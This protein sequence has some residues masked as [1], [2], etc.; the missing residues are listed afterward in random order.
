MGG[1]RGGYISLSRLDS[2][3]GR[4]GVLKSLRSYKLHLVDSSLLPFTQYTS[5]QTEI[6][7]L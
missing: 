7:Y 1:E 5:V 2:E 6:K 4:T 3:Q